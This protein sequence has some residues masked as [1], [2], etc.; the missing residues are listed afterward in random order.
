[1]LLLLLLL[2]V[3]VILFSLLDLFKLCLDFKHLLGVRCGG[4]TIFLARILL[5]CVYA[6]LKNSFA[7]FG[8]QF[9]SDEQVNKNSNKKKQIKG[10]LMSF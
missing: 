4:Q 9:L 7:L 5:T 3:A 8:I 10:W 6:L 2:L 1:M